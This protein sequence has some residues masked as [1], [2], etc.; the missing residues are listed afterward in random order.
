MTVTVPLPEGAVN[1]TDD[2]DMLKSMSVTA[3]TIE[4]VIDPLV[5]EK[6]TV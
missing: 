5:A 6:V 4:W 1:E 2:A 3:R